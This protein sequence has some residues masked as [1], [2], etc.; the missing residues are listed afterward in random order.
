[1]KLDGLTMKLIA[2]VVV[3][4]AIAAPKDELAQE[5][6]HES[7]MNYKILA[8][9]IAMFCC[10]CFCDAKRTIPRCG[11][12]EDYF[13]WSS[14]AKRKPKAIM[15]KKGKVFVYKTGKRYHAAGCVATPTTP[16]AALVTVTQACDKGLTPC[17]CV[18]CRRA[19]G[20]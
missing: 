16:A 19:W 5:M 14:S 9:A 2:F 15:S 7:E 8:I 17:K 3:V 20:I 13:K 1:M 10:G 12:F 6:A 18:E 11:W 4:V